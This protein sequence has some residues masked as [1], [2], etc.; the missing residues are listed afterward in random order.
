MIFVT[1]GSQFFIC[2]VKTSWLDGRHVVFG[3]VLEGMDIVHAIENVSKGPGDKPAED[4]IIAE[5]GEVR[6]TLSFR[7]FPH[8]L[9]SQK[10][11]ADE[12]PYLSTAF[13]RIAPTAQG[14]GDPGSRGRRKGAAQGGSLNVSLSTRVLTLL[15][16][17]FSTILLLQ[18]SMLFHSKLHLR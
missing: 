7:P 3:R 4:V 18:K 9:A 8:I 13:R 16:L 11:I 1:I 14:G 12:P 5:S 6:L 17:L 15:S 10:L 2:T